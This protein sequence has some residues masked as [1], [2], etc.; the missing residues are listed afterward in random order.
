MV[1]INDYAHGSL[2]SSHTRLRYATEDAQTFADYLRAS[3]KHAEFCC[4]R[5]LLDRQATKLAVTEAARDFVP[6]KLDLF[7]LYLAGH[8]STHSD[9]PASFYLADSTLDDLGL[10]SEGIDQLLIRAHAMQTIVFLDCCH[11]EA[12]ISRCSFFSELADS[13]ARVFLCS[14]RA[15]QRTWEDQS[16]RHGVFSNVLIRALS[17]SS[18]LM[19]RRGYVD[20]KGALF[21]HVCEQV[22]RTTF[23]RKQQSRQE[24]VQ[25][26]ISSDRVLL[27]TAAVT[28]LGRQM[29]S[30][31]ALR[32]GFRRWILRLIALLVALWVVSDLAFYH[33][34]VT[35]DGE[36]EAHSGLPFMDTIRQNGPWGNIAT[37][38]FYRDIENTTDEHRR[39][40]RR[41]SAGRIV[42]IRLHDN[43]GWDAKI[44]GRLGGDLGDELSIALTGRFPM[45]FSGVDYSTQPP[46]LRLLFAALELGVGSPTKKDVLDTLG[47]DLM[48]DLPSCVEGAGRVDFS[49]L[50][51][52]AT[53][54]MDEM[55]WRFV[56]IDSTLTSISAALR[57]SARIVSY[58][59]FH[60]DKDSYDYSS[61]QELVH[62]ARWAAK[63]RDVD[64]RSAEYVDEAWS[65]S[66][67]WCEFGVLAV[68]MQLGND[69]DRFR[70]AS[71]LMKEFLNDLGNAGTGDLLAY[72]QTLA[73]TV[74]ASAAEQDH[75][76]EAPIVLVTSALA[77]DDRGLTGT[78]DLVKWLGVI[79]EFGELPAET[80]SF[81][82]KEL[83]RSDDEFGFHG[84]EAFHILSVNAD[85]GFLAAEEVQA[86]LAWG[87]T[88]RTSFAGVG[89]F[90]EAIGILGRVLEESEAV[91]YAR[92]FSERIDTHREQQYEEENWRGDLVITASD[93]PYIKAIGRLA[94]S[95][96][97][98]VE[99]VEMLYQPAM[100]RIEGSDRVEV[101]RGISAQYG[102]GRAPDWAEWRGLL[103][104]ARD[105]SHRRALLSDVLGLIICELDSVERESTRQLLRTTWES[106]REPEIRAALGRTLIEGRLCSDSVRKG[107]FW[108]D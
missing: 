75:V 106:E 59:G 94:Q 45:G 13:S 62:L 92:S 107:E 11:A 12:I 56:R 33:L 79:A 25:G 26:G 54:V 17:S 35:E 5:T 83:N 29:S 68:I 93:V 48:D 53:D 84:L 14:S 8:G 74:F 88:N 72:R 51:P 23:V 50:N 63:I 91:E 80:R 4:L 105:D 46:P 15:G 64:E 38:V 86:V 3:S 57:G 95:H 10:D 65:E 61:I 82:F 18:P 6:I 40:L 104:G 47:Y 49:H 67:G 81:L 22:P 99:I 9:A 42:G 97:I 89:R 41:L 36:I 43:D 100:R 30:F 44:L 27:P 32:T 31:Q 77:N 39:W 20:V 60:R 85:A 58:R 34:R 101:L 1:G 2:A 66:S 102:P 24:P 87:R 16:L 98:P 90:A 21:P 69:T 70:V 7:I 55:S 76:V 52:S 96:G 73:L 28:A 19:D 103:V 37:G 71:I 78:P 108:A